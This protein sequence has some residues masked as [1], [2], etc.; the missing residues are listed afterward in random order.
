MSK[1]LYG[2][3]IQG[4]Q[5]FIFETNR[6]KE[7]IGASKLVEEIESFAK[8]VNGEVLVNAAGNIKIIFDSK[9]EAKNFYL[10]LPKKILQKA[11]GIV[12]S[13][14]V[15]KF[16][17]EKPSVDD[18]LE[19]EQRL[20]AKRNIPNIPLDYKLSIVKKAQR[21]A[22]A[23][24]Y[25]DKNEN[26]FIDKASYQKQQKAKEI[27]EENKDFS[28][29]SNKKNKLAIIHA[30][31]NS[32]GMIIPKIAKEGNLREFSKKLDASTKTAFNKAIKGIEKYRK[33]IL[34]GDDLTIVID[35]DYALKFTR[36]FL[37]FFEEETSKFLK[38]D[39]KFL[40]MPKLTACAGISIVHEKYPF[41][42]GYN[43]AEELTAYAKEIS[44]KIN[45]ILPP[46]SLMFK[47]IQSGNFQSYEIL[48]EKEL[49]A[50][51]ENKEE[52]FFDFGPYFLEKEPKI[53]DFIEIC[54][55]FYDKNSPKNRIR[56]W[57]KSLF[58]NKDVAEIDLDRINEIYSSKWDKFDIVNKKLKE[59]GVSFENPFKNKKTPF[60]EI[61]EIVSN[62]S[63]V[64]R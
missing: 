21:S 33:I 23:A 64:K 25:F 51:D 22:K 63:K 28:I 56:E 24:Y 36:D 20:R 9:D 14:A 49:K 55:Y 3:S 30:D 10:N 41:Y 29:I 31:G 2:A 48:K 34:A 58:I 57:L 52:V 6:L 32:L 42:Y 8:E 40:N 11:Y 45:K 43:L 54:D 37:K 19:L 17:G 60:Y 39:F 38:S 47:N 5:E 53:D 1:Y 16:N 46:S 61:I 50:V 7:I 27:K 12:V 35:A 44:K 18:F 26:E 13:Q 4:I 59:L 15:V 62:T